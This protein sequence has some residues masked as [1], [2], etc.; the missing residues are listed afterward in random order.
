MT[1]KRRR[2][3]EMMGRVYGWEVKDG[4]GEFFAQTVDHLFAD[5]W[6][7]PGL[8]LRDRRLLL[9]GLLAAQGLDDVAEIQIQAALHNKELDA[10]QLREAAL[11]LT[12]YVGWPLGTK[13]SM[14]VDKVIGK[15]GG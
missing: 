5:I 1:D 3:L 2:G 11:F 8:D 14:A 6:T 13:L 4:P 9:L 10:E 12:H 7:R 15:N